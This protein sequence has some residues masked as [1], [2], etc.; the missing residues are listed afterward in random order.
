VEGEEVEAR[1]EEAD[2]VEAMTLRRWKSID[3]LLLVA[4]AFR[5]TSDFIYITI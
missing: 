2:A 4:F 3:E 1:D 5:F